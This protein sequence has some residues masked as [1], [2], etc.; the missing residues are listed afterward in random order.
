MIKKEQKLKQRKTYIPA[1]APQ[2]CSSMAGDLNRDKSLSD[3]S[4]KTCFNNLDVDQQSSKTERDLRVFVINLRNNPLMPTTPTKARKLLAKNKAKVI[5]IKPFTIQLT[6]ATGEVKSNLTLGL[7]LGTKNIGFSVIDNCMEY[8][9]GQ[10]KIRQN[11]NI[12]LSQR[13]RYRRLRRSRLWYRP[14]RFLNRKKERTKGRIMPSLRYKILMHKNLVNKIKS[15]LP[16]SNI[17]IEISK[18]STDKL[19]RDYKNKNIIPGKTAEWDNLRAFILNR[20]NYTCQLCKKKGGI[21]NI[22]HIIEKKNGGSNSLDNL[23]TLHKEC[24]KAIHNKKISYTFKKPKSFRSRAAMNIINKYVLKELDAEITYG[25][26]TKRIRLNLGLKKTHYNDAFIIAGG[27]HQNRSC[28]YD[29][30]V[31]RRNNRSIQINRNGFARSVRK[32]RYPIQPRD[33]ISFNKTEYIVRGTN[34][35]GKGII[36]YYKNNRLKSIS[37]NK[38]EVKRYGKGICFDKNYIVNNQSKEIAYL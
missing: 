35:K 7:D 18:F 37:K 36:V 28:V 15:I 23:V 17:I 27:I 22:H 21:L 2:V 1:N 16:I 13:K 3:S 19:N 24:H 6:S 34:C 11:V 20:D 25:Y 9:N 32:V 38:L 8:L 33:I 31:G 5:S 10:I 26:V 30:R 14:A 12:K 4:F 29:I